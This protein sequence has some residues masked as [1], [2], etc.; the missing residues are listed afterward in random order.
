MAWIEKNKYYGSPVREQEENQYPKA[1]NLFSPKGTIKSKLKSEWVNQPDFLF[2][3]F[4]SPSTKTNI[5]SS[6]FDDVVWFMA[7]S[8][9]FERVQQNNM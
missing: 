9:K 5:R 2:F 4:F 7:C 3:L 8:M 1:E 6:N